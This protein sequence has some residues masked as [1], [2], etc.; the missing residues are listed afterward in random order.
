MV[1]I[2]Q[3]LYKLFYVLFHLILIKKQVVIMTFTAWEA[4]AEGVDI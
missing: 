2:D 1:A 4:E 3:I